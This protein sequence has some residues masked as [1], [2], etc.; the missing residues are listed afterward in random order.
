MK[1]YL[2]NSGSPWSPVT[3]LYELKVQQSVI[4]GASQ[5]RSSWAGRNYPLGPPPV[6][7]G[8]GILGHSCLPDDLI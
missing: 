4:E 6:M 8:G 3:L 2:G 5:I 7:Y 1:K